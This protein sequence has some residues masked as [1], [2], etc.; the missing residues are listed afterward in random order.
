MCLDFHLWETQKTHPAHIINENFQIWMSMMF[1]QLNIIQ[2][3]CKYL[4]GWNKQSMG[5][6][7]P[8]YFV[9]KTP[10]TFLRMHFLIDLCSEITKYYTY[11]LYYLL[12][13]ETCI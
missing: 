4:T 11:D 9:Q 12:Y 2:S 1:I 7:N 5:R 10:K 6:T 8:M 13:S 3:P